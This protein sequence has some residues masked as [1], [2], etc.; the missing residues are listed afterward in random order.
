MVETIR[1]ELKKYQLRANGQSVIRR[2]LKFSERVRYDSVKKLH[3]RDIE[4]GARETGL[5]P[6]TRVKLNIR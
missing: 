3:A 1:Q 5:K 6:P 2:M 4:A